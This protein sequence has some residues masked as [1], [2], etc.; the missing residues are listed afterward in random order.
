[1]YCP[2]TCGVADY[3]L[4]Y[5]TKTDSELEKALQDLETIANLTKDTEDTMVKMKDS[6]VVAQ[7]SYSPGN[8]T[9]MSPWKTSTHPASG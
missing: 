6:M 1:M 8:T 2:T 4:R 9:D 3:M 5:F 7:K